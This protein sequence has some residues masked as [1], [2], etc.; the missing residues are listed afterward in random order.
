MSERSRGGVYNLRV[1]LYLIPAPRARTGCSQRC[2]RQVGQVLAAPPVR[3]PSRWDPDQRLS[4]C[5]ILAAFEGASRV[6]QTEQFEARRNLRTPT[7]SAF[8]IPEPSA[9]HQQPWT[10]SQLRSS[11]AQQ[12]ANIRLGWDDSHL[13]WDYQSPATQQDTAF[14]VPSLFPQLQ[15]V[16]MEHPQ[17]QMQLP[18]SIQYPQ[19]IQDSFSIARM[20]SLPTMVLARD[21]TSCGSPDG[22][23]VSKRRRTVQEASAVDDGLYGTTTG[24]KQSF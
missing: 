5:L 7:F 23:R 2:R 1:L 15:P 9:W 10:T 20:S 22:D 3:S 8:A 19:R 12:R 18:P 13:G 4:V 17:L 24:R 6:Q 11:E 21:D 16:I 14:T